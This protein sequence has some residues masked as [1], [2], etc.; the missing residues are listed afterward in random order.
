MAFAV[1]VP[2]VYMAQ[3][4]SK[5]QTLVAVLMGS[6]SDRDT[7][8]EAVTALEEAGIACEMH[9]MSAHRTPDTVADFARNAAARGIKIIV[10]GAGLAAALPG[11]VAAYTEL[12]V[13]GVPLSTSTLG[14]LD[15]LLAIVQ[16]PKGVPVATVGIDNAKNA[17]L[18][19]IRILRA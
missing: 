11:M 2:E 17:G 5:T 18:L 14:G 13:I 8:Q 16:M 9:V 15:A 7:M 1:I 12:P 3:D 6:E 19:A 10:A 4:A